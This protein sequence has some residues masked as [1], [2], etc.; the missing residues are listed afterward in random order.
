MLPAGLPLATKDLGGL[1]MSF[2][3]ALTGRTS[4]PWPDIASRLDAATAWQHVRDEV[5]PESI[6]VLD[7]AME[8][9]SMEDIGSSIGATGTY[10]ARAGRRALEAANDDLARAM[11]KHAA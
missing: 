3:M 6:T 5:A 4:T 1:F 10:A 8:A 11:Q 2:E 7:A 9:A